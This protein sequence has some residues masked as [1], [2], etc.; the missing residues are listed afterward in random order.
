M[1]TKKI[2]PEVVQQRKYG[3]NRFINTTREEIMP[4]EHDEYG[5]GRW[6]NMKDLESWL[7]DYSMINGERIF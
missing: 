1:R 5:N 3:I 7:D 2:I 4:M 6:K